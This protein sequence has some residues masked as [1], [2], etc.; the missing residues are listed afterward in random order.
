MSDVSGTN[1]QGPAED[2][3]ETKHVVDL[4][5][6]IRTSR[7]NDGVLTNLQHLLGQNFGRRVGERKDDRFVGHASDHLLGDQ[8]TSRKTEH[9]VGADE[10]IRQVSSGPVLRKR[11]LVLVEFS[12]VQPLLGDDAL[13]VNEGDVAH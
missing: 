8:S 9:D 1:V 6:I 13:A 2:V 10:S 7:G 3:R 11:R 4:I 5:C 12:I